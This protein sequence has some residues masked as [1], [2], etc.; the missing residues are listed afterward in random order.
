MI[1]GAPNVVRGGSHNGALNA[2]EAIGAGL[3]T[4]LT[5][6]TTIPRHCTQPSNSLLPVQAIFP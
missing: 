6:D 1:L 2:A 4:V 5:S 3:C